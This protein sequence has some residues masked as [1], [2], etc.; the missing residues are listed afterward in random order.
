M[1]WQSVTPTNI[2]CG[3]ANIGQIQAIAQ[4]G[5][6][7]ISYQIL[8]GGVV[9]NTGNFI[10]LGVGVYTIMATNANGCSVSTVVSIQQPNGPTYEYYITNPNCSNQNGAINVVGNGVG[11]ITYFLNPGNI[12]NN[13]GVFSPLV[14][15]LHYSNCGCLP[16]HS[17]NGC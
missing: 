11:I 6:P 17:N 3:A 1:T 5:V 14:G 16:M 4:G 13:T 7:T 2:P 15:Y 10:N 8:P 12:T 9:N